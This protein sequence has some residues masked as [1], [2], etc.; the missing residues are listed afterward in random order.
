MTKSPSGQG[1]KPSDIPTTIVCAPTAFIDVSKYKLPPV[2]RSADKAQQDILL[3][4]WQANGLSKYPELQGA[5]T[6]L[7]ECWD[8]YHGPQSKKSPG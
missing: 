2:P 8:H 5:Y 1:I 6:E 4:K 3:R 7:R